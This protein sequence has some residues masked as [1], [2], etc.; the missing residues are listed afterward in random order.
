MADDEVS[1]VKLYAI[2]IE[3]LSWGTAK[4]RTL[5]QIFQVV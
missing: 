3:I 2:E 1:L 5:G 4:A